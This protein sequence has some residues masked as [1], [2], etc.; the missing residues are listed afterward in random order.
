MGISIEL[1]QNDIKVHNTMISWMQKHKKWLIITIWISTIAFIGAGFVGWGAYSYG[2]KASAVA[3]VGDVEITV[4]E[5][6]K[7]Y[8]DI[9]NQYA[10][11]FRGNFDKEKAK[12]FGIDK[13]ALKKLID[14]A[15][16][17]NLAKE[18]EVS[19]SDEELAK[20]I[21]SLPY[22][23]RNGKFDKQLYKQILSQNNIKI[24]DF[25]EGLRKELTIAKMLHLLPVKTSSN[26]AN[27]ADT[28]FN[29]ADKV[30]Y[31]LLNASDIQV[32]V[33]E[34]E[35]K[36]F[37]EKNKEK[38]KTEVAYVIE[39]IV[40]QPLHK[41]Y[42]DKQIQEYYND[43][44]THFRSTDG[45]ILPLDKA[46]E[47]VIAE[48]DA[49]ETKKAALRSYIDFKKGKTQ[50]TQKATLSASHNPF[51]TDVLKKVS[52]LSP[53][54]PYLK[55][56]PYKNGY[57]I[58]KLVSIIPAKIKSFEEAKAEVLPLYI[59][60]K[61]KEKLLELAK[62]SVE[63]FDGSTSDFITIKD[64]DKLKELKPDVAKKFLSKL[65]TKQ[66]KKGYVVINNENIVLYDILEQKLLTNTHKESV[67]IVNRIKQNLFDEN[68]IKTLRSKYEIEIYYKGL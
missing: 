7:A 37:W 39:Y 14:Q 30:K 23:Q 2:D 18:Y 51:D 16:I 15:L 65:F 3:K 4:A 47:S 34:K 25:E 45:K 27:I 17:L 24:K 29:I 38:F 8:S 21:A 40:Q 12:A 46:K 64:S 26:E 20:T 48:L 52:T 62:K 43:N 61:R 59:T 10:Q 49:K 19:V 58:I 11:V 56:V 28:L 66:T 13:Q 9:Y 36:M 32:N 1:H 54:S 67:Q 44:K 68:L 41:H 60:Q 50:T 6:Q 53:T 22:F 55:P 42:D 31:K 57:L 35:L 63:H 5:F 33:S